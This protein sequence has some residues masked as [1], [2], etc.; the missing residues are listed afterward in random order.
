MCHNVILEAEFTI[1]IRPKPK[2]ST[3]F[4]NKRAYQSSKINSW[5]KEFQT[6]LLANYPDFKPPID[7]DYVLIGRF[8]YFKTTNKILLKRQL[9]NTVPDCDNL[10]KALYDA[11]KGILIYDDK[12]IVGGDEVKYYSTKDMIQ[13][14]I[15]YMRY[16]I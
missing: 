12:I 16:D 8:Y 5:R 11:I 6:L 2:Q 4:G 10:D 1:P 15:T 3:R 9:K 13:F 7:Y 14:E